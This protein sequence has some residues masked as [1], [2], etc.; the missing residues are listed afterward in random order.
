M[1]VK[2]SIRVKQ[3]DTDNRAG[4]NSRGSESSNVPPRDDSDSIKSS[5]SERTNIVNQ[6]PKEEPA[7]E[8]QYNRSRGGSMTLP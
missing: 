5:I 2:K 8:R 7:E 4:S 6:I 3:A 1:D